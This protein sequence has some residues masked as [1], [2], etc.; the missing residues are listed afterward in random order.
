MYDVLEADT[1]KNPEDNIFKSLSEQET[2][3]EAELIISDPVTVI[4]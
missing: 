4:L 2:L 1:N 3:K